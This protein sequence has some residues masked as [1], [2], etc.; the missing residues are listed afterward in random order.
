MNRLRDNAGGGRR[1]AMVPIPDREAA[2]PAHGAPLK[3]CP[4][5]ALGASPSPRQPDRDGRANVKHPERLE[6]GRRSTP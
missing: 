5:P 3:R 4:R 6:I 2:S 1:E